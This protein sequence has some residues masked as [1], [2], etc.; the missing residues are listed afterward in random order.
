MKWIQ[1]IEIISRITYFLS[2][3][4]VN[5]FSIRLYL[6]R[7]AGCYGGGKIVS[8]ARN[9]KRARAGRDSKTNLLLMCYFFLI[10]F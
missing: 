1:I 10:M 6:M 2:T 3:Y 4:K 9:R 7:L 8:L 5:E